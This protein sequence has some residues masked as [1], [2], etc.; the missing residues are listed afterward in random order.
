MTGRSG[1]A[2]AVGFGG[3]LVVASPDGGGQGRPALVTGRSVSHRRHLM[4]R[5]GNIDVVVVSAA[6]LLIGGTVLAGVAYGVEG[7]PQVTFTLR[8]VAV[9]LFRPDRPPIPPWCGGQAA[10]TSTWFVETQRCPLPL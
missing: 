6:N 4:V 10:T 2:L 9:L 8:F 1:V 3:L 7:V 5:P